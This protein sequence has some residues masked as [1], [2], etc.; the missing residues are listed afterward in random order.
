ML[1]CHEELY[2]LSIWMWYMTCMCIENFWIQDVGA[3]P[4]DFDLS[5]VLD[6]PCFRVCGFEALRHTPF[7]LSS[8]G[9]NW[10]LAKHWNRKFAQV[11]IILLTVLVL[12]L[13]LTPKFVSRKPNLSLTV[14]NYQCHAFAGSFLHLCHVESGFYHGFSIWL[15]PFVKAIKSFFRCKACV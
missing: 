3:R 9:P 5:A 13:N 10:H 4:L 14:Q 2:Q 6:Y 11:T 15:N 1:L 12:I 8:C 7:N